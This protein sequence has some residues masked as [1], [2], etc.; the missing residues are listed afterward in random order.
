MGEPLVT[1]ILPTHDRPDHLPGAVASVLA[2]SHRTLQLLI[3]DDASA[4]PAATV[5]DAVAGGDRR[6]RLLRL[7]IGRG[8]AG[9]RN[10]GLAEADG[11]LVAF[12][13]DDDR[14]EPDKLRRQVEYLGRHPDVGLVTCGHHR[15]DERRPHDRQV[16][17]GPAGFDA[18]QLLWVNFAGSFS[19][20]AVRRSAVG[21]ELRVD[22]SFECAEDWDL[23]LRCARRAP[24]GVVAEPLATYVAHR[25]DR[26]TATPV[27][28]R[29]L[30]RFE[31]KH[32]GSMSADCRAFHRAHQRM[33]T[34]SG[35]GKRAHV[36][37]ALLSAPAGVRSLLV[38]EQLARQLGRI[39]RDPGLA[40]R[41]LAG[42]VAALT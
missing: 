40:E 38:R 22:E 34:G 36:A 16:F 37:A 11:E 19:F 1:V 21:D 13:D 18:G 27:K 35:W 17:L 14:W 12:L 5:V 23:W 29:G 7:D 33:D 10:A 39:R 2:Q 30:E 26:L 20:V 9:A 4:E 3:V 15:V 25:G 6:V 8:A 28:R 41:A 42:M 31:E 24:V 32:G